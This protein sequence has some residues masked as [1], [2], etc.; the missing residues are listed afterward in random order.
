MSFYRRVRAAHRPT[1]PSPHFIVD[2]QSSVS[3]PVLRACDTP[4]NCICL[5]YRHGGRLLTSVFREGGG[6]SRVSLEI[7][8]G[9]VAWK[10]HLGVMRTVNRT[11]DSV[12][13]ETVYIGEEG[14]FVSIYSLVDV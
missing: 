11:H 10:I 14:L 1:S 9:Q 6:S 2:S 5:S 12:Y 3:S 13:I 4:L 8:G 7:A